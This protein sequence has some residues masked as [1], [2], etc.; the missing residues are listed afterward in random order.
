[1]ILEGWLKP[2]LVLTSIEVTTVAELVRIVAKAFAE[3]AAIDSER[4]A[5]ELYNATNRET[6]SIGGAGAAIPHT[7]LE[8][9]D[10]TLVCLVTV[11]K[12]LPLSSIDGHPP[13]VFFF[14]LSK[15]DPYGHL[16]LLAHLAR[17]TQSQP[18]LDG[19]RR[20]KTAEEAIQLVHREEQP[21]V[22]PEGATATVPTSTDTLVVI[23]ISGEQ[24][25]DALL[26]E[27]VDLDFGEACVL[28]AQSLSEATAREVPLFVGFRDLFGDPGGRRIL[29]VE[30]TA[31]RTDAIISVVKRI[32]ERHN[33]KDARV[34]VIPTQTRWMA[35]VAADESDAGGH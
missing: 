21:L 31:D 30:S 27:L 14:L 17:L 10:E 3:V 33:A 13:D 16:L 8:G 11:N 7:E 28:E 9:L 32:S 25:V 19:L 12:P 24:A 18:L 2:A 20:A 5:A 6:V 23:S 29:V 22:T 1:M 34:S 15:P 4:I 26:V 35:P